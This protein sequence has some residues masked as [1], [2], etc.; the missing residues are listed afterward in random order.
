MPAY[1]CGGVRILTGKGFIPGEWK[2]KKRKGILKMNIGQTILLG[3]IQGLTEFL[4][5]SSS[6]HLVIFQK[7]IGLKN[8]EILLDISLHIGTLLAILIFFR[9][10]IKAI[11]TE[12]LAFIRDVISKKKT[13]SEIRRIPNAA[14]I[15]WILIGTVPT[16]II[17]IIFKPLFIHM[18]GSAFVVGLM[19]I[20]TGLILGSSLFIPVSMKKNSEP[21]LISALLV[22]LMQGAAIMPGISRSGS[23]I[24][25]GLFC[26]LNRE[27]A[28]RFSF[29]L[30]VPAII[31]ASLLEFDISKITKIGATPFIIGIGVSFIV[32]LFALKITMTLVRKGNLYYFAPYCL[33]AGIITIIIT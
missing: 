23:T 12:G 28:G 17:G 11:I 9:G 6:G 26:G 5:I 21:G 20:V 13:V 31:G 33:L 32:G 25:C 1:L 19:L 16:G 4:P 22:G 7:I 24:V 3:T 27:A 10:D 2:N 30:S 8:P 29:L 15:L 18:F 14:L